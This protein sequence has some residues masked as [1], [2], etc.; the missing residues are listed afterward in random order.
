MF[1]GLRW[2]FLWLWQLPQNVVGLVYCFVVRA[3]YVSRMGEVRFYRHGSAY[4]SVSLGN[5]IFLSRHASRRTM[6]HEYGHHRQSEWL[7][8]L[9][10]ILVGL[11]SLLWASLRSVGFFRRKP[12]SWFCIERWADVLG[13]ADRLD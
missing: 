9:Y 10:L 6:L 1:S 2:V 5:F 7:G 11:P 12:Y 13:G 8:P 3:K 4:G